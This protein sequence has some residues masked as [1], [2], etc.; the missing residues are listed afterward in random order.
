MRIDTPVFTAKECAEIAEAYADSMRE[1]IIFVH[2]KSK[3][4][5]H[6]EDSYKS[7]VEAWRTKFK[8]WEK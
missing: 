3:E 5:A 1:L 2:A 4:N 8:E 7:K 6:L